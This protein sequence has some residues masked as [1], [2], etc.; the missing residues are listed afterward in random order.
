[1]LDMG[2]LTVPL[3]ENIMHETERGNFRVAKKLIDRYLKR[4]LPLQLRLRLEYEKLRL[5]RLKKNFPYTRDRAIGV[6][7]KKISGFKEKEFEQWLREGLV[8]WIP[9]EGEMRFFSRFVDNI[10][11]LQ[12]HLERRK[13]KSR[14]GEYSKRI[15][16]EAVERI[17]HEGPRSYE[18]RAGIRIK[19]RKKIPQGERYRVWLPIPRENFQISKVKILSTEPD[20][21][22]IPGNDYGQRT[23]YF[24][25]SQREFGVEFS[26]RISEVKGGLDGD[27]SK[28]YLQEKIPHAMFTPYLKTLVE[29]ITEGAKDDF[30][31]AYRIY[32]WITH[33][34]NYTY[35]RDYSTYSNIL[36]FVSSSLRGD[37]G[38]MAL[39]FIAL[40]RLVGI[41]AKW[42]SGWYVTPRFASP[43][44]WAQVYLDGLWYPVDA[45]FGN[46]MRHREPERNEFY[47]GNLD[48]FRMVAN[49]DFLVDFVPEKRTWRWDP[50]DNQ[51]GEVEFGDI[52]LFPE[53]FAPKLYVKEFRRL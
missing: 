4:D 9:I 12:P 30:E 43:H 31:R 10:V 5:L 37:C 1:M 45:S 39:L 48:A 26:Y 7:K 27:V 22:E 32:N 50:V 36:E 17:T 21:Y 25:S 38:M 20:R 28:E 18:I 47:F 19:I 23:I 8:D 15:I 29:E 24:E 3:P 2:F 51:M 11:F 53:S 14:I 34:V 33:H 35:V 13:K 44:D 6:L 42:Q 49:D 40:C 46:A 16:K 52:T 41:P